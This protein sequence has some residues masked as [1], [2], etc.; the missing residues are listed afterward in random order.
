MRTAR[1]Y[2]LRDSPIQ[3][4]KELAQATWNLLKEKENLAPRARFELAT[5]RLTA[6]EAKNLSALSGVAYTIS[7]AIL[8]SSV[9]PNP[10]PKFSG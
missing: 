2:I 3:V 7:G 10:A 5:L 1:R 4:K 8:A 6:D 9:A